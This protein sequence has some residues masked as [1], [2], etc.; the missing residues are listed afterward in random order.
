M[1]IAGKKQQQEQF[2]RIPSCTTECL[3]HF[4]VQYK[5]MFDYSSDIFTRLVTRDACTSCVFHFPSMRVV[6]CIFIRYL[7]VCV[8]QW[9]TQPKILQ[10][11]SKIQ[12]KT[13]RYSREMEWIFGGGCREWGM[14]EGIPTMDNLSFRCNRRIVFFSSFLHAFCT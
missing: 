1:K 9:I 14:R 5:I 11:A 7:F 2:D 10:M 6:H 13:L 4:N 12:N 8:Q 3:I